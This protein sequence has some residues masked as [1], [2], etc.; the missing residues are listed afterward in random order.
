MAM[1]AETRL[2]YLRVGSL[3]LIN[4]WLV[5][6]YGLSR[7]SVES[8]FLKA[9]PSENLPF[10]WLF[11]SGCMLATIA[12]YNLYVRK[13]DILRLFAWTAFLS[14]V[15]LAAL[16]FACSRDIRS[17][18]YALY[19]WKDIYMVVLVEIFYSFANSVFP[20]RTARWAY[21][22][23][24]ASAALGAI[25]GNLSVGRLAAHFSTFHTLFFVPPMLVLVWL[26]CLPLSRRAGIGKPLEGLF[27]KEM[28]SK[29]LKVF[30]NSPYLSLILLLAFTLRIV[31]AFVD[32]G[33][34][35]AMQA[36]FSEVDSRTGMMG[37]VYAIISLGTITLNIFTGPLLRLTG[38]PI[39]LLAVP[40]LMGGGIAMMVAVPRLIIIS[41]VK[42]ASKIMDY[43]ILRSSK[44]ILYIPLSYAEKTI[45][46]SV[47]DMLAYRFAK[48]LAAVI[49]IALTACGSRWALGW[50]SF[51]LIGIWIALS[52]AIVVRFRARVSRSSEMSS[53]EVNT[54]PVEEGLETEIAPV[55]A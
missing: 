24:G 30:T 2:K 53:D 19:V 17:A 31:F 15:I 12:V 36:S 29:T 25:C 54:K 28:L 1:S 38:V 52:I 50:F 7:P 26:A 43:T 21:G 49:L 37:N 14:S 13:M 22:F 40:M 33:F 8:L 32:F 6:T 46:K 41:A 18:Y 9:Y 39:A 23:F 20:I 10:A 55:L 3:G 11:V 16:L 47:I 34:Q 45:G 27:E 35:S 42:A 5:F 48:G 51:A 44:E 4:F